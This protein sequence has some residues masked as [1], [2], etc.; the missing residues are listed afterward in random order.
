MRAVQRKRHAT[1]GFSM[2]EV[3]V[4]V[5]IVSLMSW[6]TFSAF[7]T[8]SRG[9][10]RQ[11]A[12]AVAYSLQSSLRA[13]AMRQGRL[14]CPDSDA[15]ADGY[16]NLAAG[17]C[18]AGT[19]LGWFPY[20]SVGLPLPEESVRARYAVYRQA[21]ATARLDADL[22]VSTERT[23]DTTGEGRQADV[24]DLITA[25]RNASGQATSNARAYVTGDAGAAGALDCAG[26][27]VM[28]VAYWVVVPGLDLDGNGNRLDAPH[29][30]A[31]LCATSPAAPSRN[32]S[33]D[34]VLAETSTELAG[35]LRSQLP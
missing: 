12:K 25:L 23:A 16:E 22:A 2:V 9:Q 28:N 1:L 35:W 11:Q 4:V 17:T 8:A 19:T 3:A 24:S 31:S 20:T 15:A 5:A 29:A 18:P 21:N 33:D 13:F 6:A 10:D 14:P 34:V 7:E 27:V 32:V 30:T 26:N